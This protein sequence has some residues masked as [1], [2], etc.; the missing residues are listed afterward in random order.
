MRIAGFGCA[1]FG[2]G[3]YFASQGE[4]RVGGA[5]TAQAIRL[6]IVVFGGWALVAAGA[7][8]WT[9]FALSTTATVPIGLGTALFIKLARW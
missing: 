5:I 1:F 7:L 9:V 4:G 3:L 2:L 6:G 8:L